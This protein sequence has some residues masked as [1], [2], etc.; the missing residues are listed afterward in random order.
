M[1]IYIYR[2]VQK[3]NLAFDFDFDPKIKIEL[4]NAK[5]KNTIFERFFIFNEA[6]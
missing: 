1:F 2:P 4:Q 5:S 6:N 3:F